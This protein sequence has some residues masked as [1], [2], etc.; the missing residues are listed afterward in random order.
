[1]RRRNHFGNGF[2]IYDGDILDREG[3]GQGI[4]GIQE[5]AQAYEYRVFT[6]FRFC[7]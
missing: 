1:M 3:M 7:P 2:T 5:G 4:Y 6:R